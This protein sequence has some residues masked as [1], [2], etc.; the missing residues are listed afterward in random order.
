MITSR[1][2]EEAYEY[3]EYREYSENSEYT[4]YREYRESGRYNEFSPSDDSACRRA[5]TGIDC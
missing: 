2:E 3:S 1:K 4:R 5:A